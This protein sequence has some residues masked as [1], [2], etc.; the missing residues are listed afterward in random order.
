[1]NW[2]TMRVKFKAPGIYKTAL[3]AVCICL[4]LIVNGQSA[5]LKQK[6]QATLDSLCIAGKFPGLSIGIVFP[7]NTALA[8]ASGIADSSKH[9]V[10]KTDARMMQG[11]VGKT[12]VSAIVMQ[13]I[14]EGKFSL[15]DKISKYLGHYVWF[16]RLPNAPDITIKMLMEHTSGIMRYEFKDAFTKD[17]SNNPAKVWKPEELLSYVFD[18]KPTFKAG[19]GWDYADTNYI[20]LAMIIEQVT[21]KAYYDLLYD[22]ILHPYHLTETLPS[23]KRKLKGLVQGYAGK[24][25]PFG[26]HSEVIADNG[27][28]IINPQFE[29]TG[30]GIYS[31]TL[32]LA[33]W[34]KMLY[35][36]KIFDP[37]MLPIME[38]GV[39]AKMLGPNTNY[40][41]GVI[42]RQSQKYGTIYGHSG[43]FPGYMTEMCYF[44]KYKMAFAL[45]TNTS[46]YGNLKM[47][48]LKALIEIAK[49]TFDDIS[50]L[51]Q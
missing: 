22:R 1:M 5:I 31:T 17:L 4:S 36:G 6:I 48:P 20:V 46:D 39:P 16:N 19:E 25:N 45:Q 34:G 9:E 27:E 49:L 42:I 29:W 21:G 51:E 15:D 41:L 12:Y 26:G 35:E 3:T 13:L 32:D 7:D 37:S 18:E 2:K 23:N 14:K 8:F 40:G 28:F 38:D 10:M 44:P 43:F 11:S 50:I 33:K 47:S 30:G 24:D